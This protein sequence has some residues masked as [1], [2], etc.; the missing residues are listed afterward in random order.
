LPELEGLFGSE[1]EEAP[2]RRDFF[3]QIGVGAC[4]VA[5]VASGIVTL[6]YI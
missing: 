1:E 2:T 3:T 4:A 5:A 6:D